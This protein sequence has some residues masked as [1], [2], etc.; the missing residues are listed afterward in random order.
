M[1][2]L[3]PRRLLP[4]LTSPHKGGRTALTCRFR[5]GNQCA[6]DVLNT[7]DNTYFGDVVAEAMSRRGVLRAGALG[8]L[9]AGV[10]VTTA[11]PAAADPA[12]EAQTASGFGGD[13]HGGSGLR[14]TAVPP[15]TD[16]KVTVPEGYETAPVVRWGDPVL[17]GA[18]AFDFEN[19]TAAAQ[20]AQFGYNCDFVTFF[21][22]GQQRGLLWVNHEYTDENLMFRG[23]KS[24][25][26]AS[27]EQIRI[28][29]AAHGGS[30][31]EVERVGRSGR[32]KL[33][34]QGR[35]RYNR[36]V[37]AQTPMAFSGPAA[38]GDLLKT[39]A[40]PAG[41]RP[42]G[43]LNNCAGGT[44]PWG[45]VLSGEEN[46]NQYF[47]NGN[48]VPEAQKPSLTRYGVSATTGIPSGNRR[49]DRVEE[50]FDLAKHPNEV[51]RFGWIV[52]IDPFDPDSTPVKRTALGRLAHEGA[53]TSLAGD[54]RVVAYMGD[55]SRFEYVYKFV[56]K[57]RYIPGFDRH[58]R[59]LLDEGT[60]YVAR[61][62]GDSP[63]A[64]IDGTGKLPADGLFDGSGEWIP[65]VTGDVSHV[66]GMTAQEVLVYTRLAADKVGATKMDRPEDVKRNP[67]TGGVYVALTNNSNRTPA[68]V[69]EA[70]P[71]PSNKHGHILEIAERRNDAGATTFAWSLPLVCGDPDDPSTYFGG[72]DKSKV[73]PISCPDNVAFDAEG[74]LWISTDGNQLGAH[75]GLF[76]MPVRGS[77]RGHLRQFLSVPVGAETCGPLVS[78]D[79]RSVFVA[80]QHPGETN[81]ATP[82]APTSHWPD[83]GTSQPRPAVVVAWHRQGKKIGS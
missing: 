67:V 40:D 83:G 8:A 43:M 12:V 13:R 30:V 26:T 66:P 38:G 5:C 54:G 3:S 50:R 20:A 53:T 21:P 37:T 46:F 28:A 48:G 75:D 76:A 61:F 1:A 55:D 71:R 62:T 39:A 45:T 16:D 80:V 24:G 31:V 68:Q 29:L 60:L 32:W 72:F 77:E 69:D 64:E 51:N 2:N 17:P 57:K 7:S 41:A 25:D 10:G 6:H 79:Q 81:G 23:Y 9:V 56:S 82:E 15:N 59:T 74:N 36:R 47:V 78:P 73:S 63:A 19:Q 14:F 52:E 4:L 11:V 58:N 42:L 34:T 18:P 27:E 49:F 65:L 22:L 33:V 44:T 35:R 70:N